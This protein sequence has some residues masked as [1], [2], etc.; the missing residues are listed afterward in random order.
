V[1]SSLPQAI[2]VRHAASTGNRSKVMKGISDYPVHEEGK[3]DAKR[4]AKVIVRYKPTIVVTSPLERAKCSAKEIAKEAGVLLKVDPKFLPQDLG[5]W[6]G[7]PMEEYEPKLSELATKHPDEDVPGG[8]SFNNFLKKKVKPSFAK[9]RAMIKNGERPVIVTHSRNLRQL[10]H[11]LRIGKPKDPT[12]G[13]PNPGKFV[14][15]A[16]GGRLSAGS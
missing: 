13:G 9:I 1:S 5:E 14:M 12:K 6:E 11:G 15:L 2:F 8:E 10:D 3:K 4:L 16:K 7:K